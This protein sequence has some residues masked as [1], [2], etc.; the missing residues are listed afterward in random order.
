MI[1]S[2]NG[3][4]VRAITCRVSGEHSAPTGRELDRRAR[5]R[6]LPGYKML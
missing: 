1:L 6:V 2:L 5:G 4:H 3:S